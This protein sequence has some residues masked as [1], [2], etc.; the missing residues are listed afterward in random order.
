MVEGC[1]ARS[2]YLLSYSYSSCRIGD[3]MKDICE[4]YANLCVLRP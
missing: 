4:Q 1:V 2:L 3:M